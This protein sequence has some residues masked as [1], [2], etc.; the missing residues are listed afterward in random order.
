MT[1]WE[2]SIETYILPY[3]KWVASGSLLCD[4]GNPKPVLHDNLEGGL[5]KERHERGVQE[6]WDIYI[7]MADAYWCMAMCDE[8]LP[9]PS[10][11]DLP[12]PGL[13]PG[14]LHCRQILYHWA[15]REAPHSHLLMANACWC[16]AMRDDGLPLPSPGDLPNPGLNPGLLHCRQIL[17][18]WATREAP[19]SHLP[20]ADACWC[21]VE[22]ITEL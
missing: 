11:G 20:P 10:P 7:P 4:A 2:N 6:G 9:L 16:V 22:T 3:V 17:Y 18:H 13:N 21:V 12:N 8:G 15:T 19:H 5:E 1:I 14:L